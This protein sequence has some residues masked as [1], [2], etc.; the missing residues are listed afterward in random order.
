MLVRQKCPWW[1]QTV[2]QPPKS[3]G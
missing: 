3:G 1:L 2:K